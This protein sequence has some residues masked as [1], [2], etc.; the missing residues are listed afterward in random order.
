MTSAVVGPPGR[1]AMPGQDKGPGPEQGKGARARAEENPARARPVALAVVHLDLGS[2]EDPERVA[3]G[4]ALAQVPAGGPSALARMV[5]ALGQV[6][7]IREVGVVVTGGPGAD[8]EGLLQAEADRLKVRW[9]HGSGGDTLARLADGLRGLS[10]DDDQVVVLV[11]G[12]SPLLSPEV[13][14]AAVE[15]L[16]LGRRDVVDTDLGSGVLPAGL[17]LAALGARVLYALDAALPPGDERR[18]DPAALL[19]RSPLRHRVHELSPAELGPALE[20]SGRYYASFHLGLRTEED[21][22]R[23]QFMAGILDRQKEPRALST[24]LRLLDQHPEW[25]PARDAVLAR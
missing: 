18:A 14:G 8:P 13:V 10:I 4:G 21:V 24:L 16:L 17:D 9:V 19:R 7:W 25:R 1:E 20:R 12:V 3:L 23:L 2:G 6:A 15:G 11:H 5:V 22:A